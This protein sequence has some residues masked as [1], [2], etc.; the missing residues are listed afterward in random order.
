MRLAR[1]PLLHR[2]TLLLASRRVCHGAGPEGT[3]FEDG[4]VGHGA[5]TGPRR[6]RS[7]GPPGGSRAARG[8]R[9]GRLES[10]QRSPVP[11]TGGVAISPTARG[12]GRGPGGVREVD[13]RGI[14]PRSTAVSERRL[15]SRPVVERRRCVVAATA[16]EAGALGISRDRKV[17]GSG[18]SDLRTTQASPGNRT[19]LH[20]FTARGLATSLATQTRREESN[21]HRPR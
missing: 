7:R 18:F 4:P 3:V 20:G 13:D 2:A 11:K 9:S 17:R 21:P 6:R 16:R 5:V 15:P 12:P 8:A 1:K 10:N 19:L 14:E